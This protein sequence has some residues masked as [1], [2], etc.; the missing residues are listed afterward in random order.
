MTVEARYVKRNVCP[1]GYSLLKST[2]P[3]GALY[4]I[5]PFRYKIAH[6]LCGSCGR[7]NTHILCVWVERSPTGFA[8][9]VPQE[10]F[11]FTL[12]ELP[13]SDVRKGA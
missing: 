13:P 9:W 11:E 5:D 7:M 4:D 3:L 1:C 6:L 10:I 2:I 8:G 12:P